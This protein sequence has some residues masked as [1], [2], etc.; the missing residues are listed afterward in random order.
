MEKSLAQAA[1][2]VLLGL[3]L[4]LERQRSHKAEPELFAGIRTFPV[5]TLG[6]YLALATG[7]PW[8]LALFMAAIGGLAIAAYVG[9]GKRHGG[10][11]TEVVAVCAPLL[12]AL[13]HAD[14]ALLAAASTIVVTL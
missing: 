4:G 12:G 6:G 13:V 11:T 2:A 1:T 10:A 5:I 8:L 9:G 7:Q 14:Q 3:L